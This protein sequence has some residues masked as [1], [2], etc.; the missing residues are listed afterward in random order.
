MHSLKAMRLPEDASMTSMTCICIHVAC[1]AMHET[2]QIDAIGTSIGPTPTTT[3]TTT[4]TGRRS[5]VSSRVS[6][7]GAR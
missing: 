6:R 5:D 7:G 2:T 3:P 1:D 4:W